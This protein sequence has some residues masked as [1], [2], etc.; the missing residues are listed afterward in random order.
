MT[1]IDTD[2]A[3]VAVLG[4]QKLVPDEA[5]EAHVNMLTSVSVHPLTC[6]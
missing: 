1:V 3:Q 4:L 5:G 6:Y 2:Q